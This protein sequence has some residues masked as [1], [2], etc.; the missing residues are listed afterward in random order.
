MKRL[1]RER[2]AA[3]HSKAKLGRLADVNPAIITWAEQRS[4][5]LYPVQLERLARALGWTGAPEA[6]LE[7]VPE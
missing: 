3:G 1:E 7:E 2:L 5:E 4:F 6:L